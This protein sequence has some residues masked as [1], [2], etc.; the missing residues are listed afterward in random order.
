MSPVHVAFQDL[1]SDW[2]AAEV[3]AHGAASMAA[4]V[5][6]SRQQSLVCQDCLPQMRANKRQ[7]P[8]HC[9]GSEEESAYG[10]ASNAVD[11]RVQRAPADEAA[12]P[13][14]RGQHEGRAACRQGQR[15]WPLHYVRCVLPGAPLCTHSLHCCLSR[16]HTSRLTH[17]IH[18][19]TL[20]VTHTHRIGGAHAPCRC[21]PCSWCTIVPCT[22]GL[23]R[24][25]S[26]PPR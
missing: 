15:R 9:R 20:D 26:P 11:H 19:P 5:A 7:Q 25:T 4:H 21:V 8:V 1:S 12:L 24:Q 13:L 23:P 10:A 17:H 14:Q 3:G 16:S 6:R 22:T 2:G 18:P